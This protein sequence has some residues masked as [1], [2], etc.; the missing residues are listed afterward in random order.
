MAIAGLGL[1]ASTV[2]GQS[3]SLYVR[4]EPSRQK[5]RQEHPPP[6]QTKPTQSTRPQDLRPRPQRSVT[7]TGQRSAPHRLSP[8]VRDS[9]LAA[10]RVPERREFAVNDLVTIIIRE[11]SETDFNASLETE[12]SSEHSGE[13]AE[14]PRLTLKDLADLQV[15]SNQF[16]QGNPQL[17]VQS[18]S[19]F[20][21]EGDYSRSEEMT[22]RLTARIIDVKP[23]GTLVV[24]A[25]KFMKS[26]EETLN[27][28]LTGT[29][30]AEDITA[31]NT[32]LST[33][34]YDLHLAKTHDGALRESTDK[35][36]FTE[37]LDFIFNF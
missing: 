2:M 16:E 31:D 4:S 34:L 21:G 6:Q 24:E 26:D 29:C 13:I 5:A 20:E 37:I 15:R 19:E 28:T 3:S 17:D 7:A 22:G 23:N 27:I 36:L 30:R 25:K 8:A 10:V 9:S 32:V 35:G 14:F 18:E 11:S 12:K 1:I 33:Q